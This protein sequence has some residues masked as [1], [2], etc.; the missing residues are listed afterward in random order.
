MWNDD[1]LGY[2][3]KFHVITIIIVHVNTLTIHVSV[4]MLSDL[5]MTKQL[6]LI[7]DVLGAMKSGATEENHHVPVYSHY[8]LSV[9]HY[10]SVSLST[11]T[12]F[13]ILIL[14]LRHIAVSLNEPFLG[15]IVPLIIG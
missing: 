9:S 5:Y 15:E 12:C 2:Y 14:R 7:T 3:Y 1:I 6:F 4:W 11:C 8:T 10:G 13:D